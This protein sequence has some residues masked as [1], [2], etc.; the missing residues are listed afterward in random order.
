MNENTNESNLN[1]LDGTNYNNDT[2]IDLENAF[3]DLISEFFETE[4]TAQNIAQANN[5]DNVIENANT[6]ITNNNIL[7]SNLETIQ[8]QDN[9]LEENAGNI[10]EFKL[11]EESIQTNNIYNKLGEIA[12]DEATPN[13]YNVIN[14]AENQNIQADDAKANNAIEEDAA[15][16]NNTNTDFKLTQGN[17]PAKIGFWTKLRNFFMPESKLQYSVQQ[18][19]DGNTGIWNKLQNFFSFGNK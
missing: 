11:Q 13:A 2:E 1:N 14:F 15:K 18:A 10:A 16:V 9:Y 5:N 12:T 7:Y 3:S 4:N 19:N 8:Q 6:N 17:L